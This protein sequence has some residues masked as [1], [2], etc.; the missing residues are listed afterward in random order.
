MTARTDLP[1]ASPPAP[2]A[3]AQKRWM[4]ADCGFVYDEAAGRP[5]DGIAPGT[6]WADVPEDW[7]CPDCGAAKAQFDMVEIEAGVK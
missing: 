4:C 1:P 6:R 2:A 7:R 3:A 5:Q